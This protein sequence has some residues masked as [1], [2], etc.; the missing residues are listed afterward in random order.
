MAKPRTGAKAPTSS[1]IAKQPAAPLVSGEATYFEDATW[2][3]TK[4]QVAQRF[5]IK[6]KPNASFLVCRRKLE[7]VPVEVAF[8]F[9]DGGLNFIEVSVLRTYAEW[10]EGD[11]DETAIVRWIRQ[12]A[13]DF[14]ERDAASVKWH[15]PTAKV[16]TYCDESLGAYFERVTPA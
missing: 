16:W 15:M 11:A 5:R 14:S 4:E 8:H 2:G 10:G 13:G 3:M 7:G 9:K 12:W 1:R 6:P